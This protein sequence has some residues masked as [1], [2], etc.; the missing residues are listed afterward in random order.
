[1]A[2]AN[3]FQ[4]G[5]DEQV[6]MQNI[7]R[8]RQYA[9]L[10]RQKATDQQPKGEM[11]GGHYVAP[12]WTQGLAQILN[13][14]QGGK[15]MREADARQKALGE[16]LTQR[17]T[18]ESGQFSKLLRGEAA[19]EIQ[20][21]TPNDDDGNAMPVAN[22]A[23]V[24]GNIGAAYD[25]AA[26][27]RTPGLQQMGMQGQMQMAQE[28]AKLAQA[29]AQR[30]QYMAIIQSAPSP[31]AAIAAGVPGSVVDEFYKAKNYGRDK[32]ILKDI[33]GSFVPITE[34]GD[35]PAGV[36]T[37]QKTN[38]PEA[39]LTDTRVRSEGAL[40]RGVTV[41]GQDMTDS[42][43]R[44]ST[45]AT[46]S[47]PFEVTGPDGKPVLVQQDKQ[48]NI[49]P[50]QGYTAKTSGGKPMTDM[51]EA[52]YRT[53]IAK[54]YQSANTILANMDEVAASAAAV[55]N[56]KGL[57]GATGLQAYIPSYPDSDASQAEVR[58]NN[59]EGKITNL[60]KAAA[61][62]SGAIGPMAVQEW[63][64]V[65]DMVAA[66]EPRKG[67]K[68]LKEQI[69]L[70]EKTAEGASS[71]IR[72]AYGKHYGEDF[73]RYPQF[74]VIGAPNSAKPKAVKPTATKSGATVGN[75]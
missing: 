59:L 46:M 56:S 48:G 5:F 58:L 72:D 18:E 17:R 7:E 55:K 74:E 30:K 47:K 2:Q 57:G 10:L 67:E 4:P 29:E 39:L 60:G 66:I 1:M 23:A 19:R 61:S 44:D 62:M 14:Y 31:Q 13:A 25:Y 68:S 32:V 40:N 9:Q 51:Q 69:E 34:Y 36:A 37:I 8:Q 43:S 16:A 15:G 22:K 54:D 35:T 75:W 71:R 49:T 50:V 52:K 26:S 21:L 20:P 11:V 70:V 45:A 63:K 33:G 64:I 3:F 41:R 38:T 24:P 42:R 73:G 28:Q 12:S 27:A 65:R 6:E 53:Q